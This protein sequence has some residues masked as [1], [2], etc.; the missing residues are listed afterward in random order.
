MGQGHAHLA[1][2]CGQMHLR[3]ALLRAGQ[4]AGSPCSTG[5]SGPAAVQL[6]MGPGPSHRRQSASSQSGKQS[7]EPELDRRQWG[8]R[9]PGR[10]SREVGLMGLEGQPGG[11]RKG[12]TLPWPP[13]LSREKELCASPTTRTLVSSVNGEHLTVASKRRATQTR[14]PR[15]LAQGP[16][17]GQGPKGAGGLVR[18]LGAP[19][20]R[21]GPCGAPSRCARAE[22][23]PPRRASMDEDFSSQMKKVALAMGTSLSDK[24]ISLLP[25]DVRH[26]GTAHPSHPTHPPGLP[27]ARP[28]VVTADLACPSR[29]LQLPQVLRAHAEVPGLGA[30][31][32]RHP[33]GLPD[34]GQGQ[35]RLH[36]MERDQVTAMCGR[37]GE[38]P[39]RWALG[40]C[41]SLP[42]CPPSRPGPRRGPHPTFR[43]VGPQGQHQT[44]PSWACPPP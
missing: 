6:Q 32:G 21:Q 16:L 34:A 4:G 38:V 20:R 31:G 43:E 36:R 39:W 37:G 40:P 3:L 30:A 11:E 13:P 35:E 10:L 2:G 12:Q 27:Q 28:G 15:G 41:L 1:R 18:R 33:Q 7:P 42:S 17:Q 29:H 14:L 8:F 22:L 23:A 9:S 19:L 25:T 44:R 24:D 26:H 5:S